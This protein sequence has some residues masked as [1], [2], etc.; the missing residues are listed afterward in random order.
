MMHVDTAINVLEQIH[1]GKTH[2]GEYFSTIFHELPVGIAWGHLSDDQTTTILDGCNSFTASILD[3]SDSEKIIGKSDFDVNVKEEYAQKCI[4]DSKNVI[5]YNKPQLK[6]IRQFLGKSGKS[7]F[8]SISRAPIY[9]IN[10]NITGVLHILAEI[11]SLKE[12]TL[13]R[14]NAVSNY[15]LMDIYH[16]FHNKQNYFVDIA[17]NM[18]RLTA[19]QAECLTHLSMGKTIKQISNILGC[20]SRTIEDHI[21]LLKRKLDVYSTAELIDCFW[22]NPIRWF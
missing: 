17:G 15:R 9:G 13:A 1:D 10:K 7:A 14:Y 19:R 18:I 21:N 22:R 4:D 11:G 3:F 6:I 5:A 20:S 8:F 2:V 12:S 16:S